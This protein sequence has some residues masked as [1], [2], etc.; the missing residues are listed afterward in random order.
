MRTGMTKD[1][2]G[3]WTLWVHRKVAGCAGPSRL[4]SVSCVVLTGPS[5]KL[6]KKVC[7]NTKEPAQVF[8]NDLVSHFCLPKRH[9]DLTCACGIE[10]Q[11]SAP[12][13]FLYIRQEPDGFSLANLSTSW[14][15]P[16]FPKQHIS[17][18]LSGLEYYS[19][20]CKGTARLWAD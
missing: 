11:I 12:Y 2:R 9:T 5:L 1:L 17:K 3:A 10:R 19:S 14:K 16:I 20:I 13:R 4:M 6:K 15:I 7:H 8:D 18:K